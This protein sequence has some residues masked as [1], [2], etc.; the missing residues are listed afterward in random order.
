MFFSSIISLMPGIEEK[1]K[2]EDPSPALGRRKRS[3]ERRKDRHWTFYSSSIILPY[4]R[5][6][7][8][9]VVY[10][11]KKARKKKKEK[12]TD[13]RTSCFQPSSQGKKGKKKKRRRA[14]AGRARSR[15]KT[16][17]FIR[18]YILHIEANI[19]KKRKDSLSKIAIGKEVRRREGKGRKSFVVR[20][21]RPRR[22]QRVKKKKKK[23]K[24]RK[25]YENKEK[26][27]HH[28]RF[29]LSLEKGKRKK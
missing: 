22:F 16:R 12:I 27:L 28:F 6:R 11:A 4:E 10:P 9:D 29:F 1:K 21:F 15:G 7:I 3:G 5:K 8:E 23:G 25:P 26:S 24:G 20:L 2:R 19:V 14:V 13:F 18:R 17:L